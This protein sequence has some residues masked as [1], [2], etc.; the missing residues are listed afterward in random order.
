VV[1]P[2]F[3]E[4]KWWGFIGFDE[5]QKEREWS[6][7]EIGAL[8]TAG[9]IMGALIERRQA[10]EA[11]LKTEEH[12]R[13]VIENIFKFVPEGLLAFTER[14]ELLRTN[15]AFQDIVKKY[16]AKL[17]YT[18]EELTE[19]LIEQVKNRIVNKDYS[20]IRISKSNNEEAKDR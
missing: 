10:E 3:V 14:L 19:I 12:F 5:C 7:A 1:V 6:T 17:H 2:I 9:A 13:K 8:K 18:E 4:G 16:S 15:K 11:R 20:E